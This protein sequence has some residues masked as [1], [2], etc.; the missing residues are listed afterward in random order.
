MLEQIASSTGLAPSW[1]IGKKIDI[2]SPTRWRTPRKKRQF[3]KY[4]EHLTRISPSVLEE[5]SVPKYIKD[6]RKCIEV[7]LRDPLGG[8][9]VNIIIQKRYEFR[10]PDN[11]A[12][13]LTRAFPKKE[14][15]L[16][17]EEDDDL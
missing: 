12:E 3:A 1:M 7:L 2:P 17:V 13:L 9:W 6:V 4:P 5:E 11:I 10:H 16:P 14:P 8:E 15:D